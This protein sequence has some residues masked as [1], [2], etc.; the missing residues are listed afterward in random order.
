MKCPQCR[1]EMTLSDDYYQCPA[2]LGEFFPSTFFHT[3]EDKEYMRLW[4]LS[5]TL[6]YKALRNEKE[7]TRQSKKYG[8]IL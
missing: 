6:Y 5:Q 7:T 2:C 1:V 3:E 8:F 4:E